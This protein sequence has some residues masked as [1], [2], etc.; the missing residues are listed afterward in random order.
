MQQPRQLRLGLQARHPPRLGAL[1]LLVL[2]LQEAA[3]A[4]A[5]RR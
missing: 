2:L 1:L 3:A 4:A 5:A